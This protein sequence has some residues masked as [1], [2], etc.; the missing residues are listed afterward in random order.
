MGSLS[1]LQRIFP[2]QG[3]NLGVPQCRQILRQLSHKGNP[4]IQE[5]VDYPSPMIFPTQESIQG[6]LHCRQILY[7]LSYEG[8]PGTHSIQLYRFSMEFH[9][10]TNNLKELRL[11]RERKQ[12]PL[13]QNDFERVHS[14]LREMPSHAPGLS[15]PWHGPS[16]KSKKE[17]IP[18]HFAKAK[19]VKVCVQGFL[20]NS[21]SEFH[22]INTGNKIITFW[23][24]VSRVHN[25]C[26]AKAVSCGL[27]PLIRRC[28]LNPLSLPTQQKE[29]SYRK[30]ACKPR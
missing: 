20:V 1:F 4:R 7:Q 18:R 5:W 19:W 12:I 25:K 9:M 15:F 23:P 29:K 13:K 22:S 3:S 16:W 14:N 24:Q 2:T 28:H 6:L 8:N 27:S 26:P 17:E 21:I 10:W 30:W 11:Y